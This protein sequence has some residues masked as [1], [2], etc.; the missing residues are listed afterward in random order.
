MQT[1][2][3]SGAASSN[4]RQF[5]Q[6]SAAATAAAVLAVGT[7]FAAPA[8]APTTSK[9]GYD[10]T[11][12]SQEEVEKAAASFTNLQKKVLLKVRHQS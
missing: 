5:V 9:S 8:A 3:A 7:P 6:T 2:S 1:S 4:R 12:M 11:P 10:L